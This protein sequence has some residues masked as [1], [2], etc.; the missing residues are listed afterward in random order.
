MKL[1]SLALAATI[2]LSP[3]AASAQSLDAYSSNWTIFRPSNF[4]CYIANSDGIPGTSSPDALTE[5][6]AQAGDDYTVS[7]KRLDNGT[8]Y[9]VKIDFTA[10]NIPTVAIYFTSMSYCDAFVGILHAKG[11][12]PDSYSN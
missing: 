1:L 8:V 3:L 9:A 4:K 6:L 12:T 11:I 5:I 10:K 2:S 7:V